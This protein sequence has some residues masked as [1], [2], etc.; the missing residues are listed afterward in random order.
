M[1]TR[2]REAGEYEGPAG[3]IELAQHLSRQ[4]LT[5]PVRQT[6]RVIGSVFLNLRFDEVSLCGK[7]RYRL[8]FSPGTV[9]VPSVGNEI[10]EPPPGQGEVV[11]QER[12]SGLLDFYR[13]AA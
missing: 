11:C 13:R 8:R 3:I 12:L 7:Y 10:I 9:T 4:Y 2:D 5:L 6:R 1:S